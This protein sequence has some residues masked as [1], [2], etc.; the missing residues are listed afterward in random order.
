MI[1]WIH[2]MNQLIE[3]MV[4]DG[5]YLASAERDD[6]VAKPRPHYAL[7][8]FNMGENNI[9]FAEVANGI[10]H[11]SMDRN[12]VKLGPN[13]FYTHFPSSSDEQHQLVEQTAKT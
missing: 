12:T 6:A 9:H 8:R 7:V 11:F 5:A 2:V 3:A 1:P 10:A 4:D 13:L